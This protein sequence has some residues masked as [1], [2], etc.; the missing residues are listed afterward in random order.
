MFWISHLF[1]SFNL[2]VDNGSLELLHSIAVDNLSLLALHIKGAYPF[3]IADQ[4]ICEHN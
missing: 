3:D 2:E 4:T 1:I